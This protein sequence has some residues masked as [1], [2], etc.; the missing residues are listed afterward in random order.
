[1]LLTNKPNSCWQIYFSSII[2]DS[3]RACISRL[4][5]I[6]RDLHIKV[7]INPLRAILNSDQHRRC[8]VVIHIL[9]FLGALFKGCKCCARK[10]QLTFWPSLIVLLY[11]S[12]WYTLHRSNII[13]SFYNA[14]LYITKTHIC[15]YVCI[16]IYIAVCITAHRNVAVFCVSV[17]TFAF[18]P[19]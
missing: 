17:H 19:N 9:V 2:Y 16:N 3:L 6:Y 8:C 4:K 1:M 7:C 14:P 10:R 13:A 12:R 18:A 15:T 11:F 5:A